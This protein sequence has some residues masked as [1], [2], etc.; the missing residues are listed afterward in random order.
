MARHLTLLLAML[1]TAIASIASTDDVWLTRAEVSERLKVP[2]KTLA[3]WASQKKGPP[4]RRFG[5]HTRYRL[6]ECISWENAQFTGGD[7]A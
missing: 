6:S 3:Q 4:Y 5:R 1:L 2:E 7:A